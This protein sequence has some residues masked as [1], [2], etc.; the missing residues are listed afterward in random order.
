MGTCSLSFSMDI[1]RNGR[2]GSCGFPTM[3]L[4]QL[5]CNSNRHECEKLGLPKEYDIKI[6]ILKDISLGIAKKY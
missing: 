1:P 4:I 3:A 2:L 5:H 6:Q